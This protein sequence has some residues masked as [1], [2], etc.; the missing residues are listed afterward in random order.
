[1]AGENLLAG[2]TDLRPVGLEA[3]E[4]PQSVIGID[5]QLGL[6]KPGD[7]RMAGGALLAITLVCGGRRLRRECLGIYGRHG[8][9]E[10]DR[11]HRYPDH[12]PLGPPFA[13]IRPVA[14]TVNLSH[15]LPA[16]SRRLAFPL[17]CVQ[18][19]AALCDRAAT[20]LV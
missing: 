12:G 9:D 7:V 1:V 15:T 19:F 18:R 2:A 20:T 3:T 8:K 11:Q 4:N 16:L 13:G 6:A 10:S 17:E 5:L 14:T